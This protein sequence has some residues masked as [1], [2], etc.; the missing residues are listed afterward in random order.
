MR[1][2]SAAVAGVLAIGALSSSAPASACECVTA[3]HPCDAWARSAA[4]FVGRVASIRPLDLP[5]ALPDGG[6]VPTM[7]LVV[8]LTVSESFKGSVDPTIE[9]ATPA[10]SS[11]CGFAF[12]E[13]R[14][15]LVSANPESSRRQGP[16]LSATTCGYASAI[17]DAGESL[18]YLRARTA[19]REPAGIIHGVVR[20]RA[21]VKA[22][23]PTRVKGLASLRVRAESPAGT[24]ET[25]TDARGRFVLDGLGPGRYV[26]T[27][28]AAGVDP[29]EVELSA[30]GCAVTWFYWSDLATLKGRFVAPGNGLSLQKLHAGAPSGDG[31][32]LAGVWRA[33]PRVSRAHPREKLGCRG[34]H[35]T[36]PA[37]RARDVRRGQREVHGRALNPRRLRD[38]YPIRW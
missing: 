2:S 7:T 21:R 20:S 23:E 8:R 31:G 19:A 22:H 35:S 9:V 37:H 15:Y 34:L 1:W 12:K 24:A 3:L 17:E 38:P 25:L 36:P 4:I 28:D 33:D 16:A 29:A 30:G 6:W 11:A 14:S 27:A 18:L 13:G 10:S 26:V 5:R 32:R